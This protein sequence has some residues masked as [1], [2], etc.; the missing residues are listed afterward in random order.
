MSVRK[1]CK[2]ALFPLFLGLSASAA[3][4]Q[5]APPAPE[6]PKVQGAPDVK[7][8]AD[9][10]AK[11]QESRKACRDEIGKSEKGEKGDRRAK[12]EACMAQKHPEMAKM[13]ACRKE[14]TEQKLEPKSKEHR[15]A[16]RACKDRA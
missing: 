1:F 10:K 13:S 15:A 6:A 16:M 11:M 3:M 12:M 8:P 9:L 2:I 5:A 7:V 4:A 14:V